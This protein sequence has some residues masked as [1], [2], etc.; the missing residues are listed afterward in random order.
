MICSLPQLHPGDGVRRELQPQRIRSD[1]RRRAG[2]ED[3]QAI[4]RGVEFHQT[5]LTDL[6]GRKA[7]DQFIRRAAARQREIPAHE[8]GGVA[9]AHSEAVDVVGC[10]W[11]RR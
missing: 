10:R 11:S 9:A 8:L 7:Q 1:L 2:A 5:K 3:V 6:F 4:G